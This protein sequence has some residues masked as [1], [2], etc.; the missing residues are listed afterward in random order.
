MCMRRLKG[1]IDVI[2]EILEEP[3]DQPSSHTRHA[4]RTTRGTDSSTW[5]SDMFQDM[6]TC[7]LRQCSMHE[8]RLWCTRHPRN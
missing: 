3:Y 2:C 5:H 6:C 1:L 7:C 8:M 4:S